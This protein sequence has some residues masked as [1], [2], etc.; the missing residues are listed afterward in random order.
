MSVSYNNIG[1]SL[2]KLHKKHTH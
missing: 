1:F 2:K